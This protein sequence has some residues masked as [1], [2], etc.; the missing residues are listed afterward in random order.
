MA[1]LQTDDGWYYV[2]IPLFGS[3]PYVGWLRKQLLCCLCISSR[4]KES[5]LLISTRVSSS[6]FS[7]HVRHRR[8]VWVEREKR[9]QHNYKSLQ[10]SGLFMCSFR[11]LVTLAAMGIYCSKL[12]YQQ[13]IQNDKVARWVWWSTTKAC[14][15]FQQAKQIVPSCFESLKLIRKSYL[16]I[17]YEYS[18]PV[19]KAL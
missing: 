19:Y 4:T 16:N 6:A 2:G 12:I 5:L 17:E 10:L 3:V 7:I 1:S 8:R 13:A 9:K 18:H 14:C 15:K 11:L